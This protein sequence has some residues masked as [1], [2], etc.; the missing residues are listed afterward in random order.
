MCRVRILGDRELSGNT[1]RDLQ[2]KLQE[3]E[4]RAET[5]SGAIQEESE[6]LKQDEDEQSAVKILLDD[7]KLQLSELKKSVQAEEQR[8][9]SLELDLQMNEFKKKR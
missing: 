9:E 3:L 6:R 8:Q 7:K 2:P 5:L 1:C 4:H